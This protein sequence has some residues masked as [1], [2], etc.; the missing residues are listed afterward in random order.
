MIRANLR[1][2]DQSRKYIN[3]D[4]ISTFQVK[5]SYYTGKTILFQMKNGETFETY[6]NDDLIKELT[7]E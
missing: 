4:E 2:N 5:H 7:S 3:K 1:D 6:H